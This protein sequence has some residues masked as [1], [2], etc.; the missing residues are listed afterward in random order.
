LALI[1]GGHFV[2]LPVLKVGILCYERGRVLPSSWTAWGEL[3]GGFFPHFFWTYGPSVTRGSSEVVSPDSWL[4]SN[5]W[6][7]CPQGRLQL[8]PMAAHYQFVQG[9]LFCCFHQVTAALPCSCNSGWL[10]PSP[11]KWDNSI[12]CTTLSP[13][14]SGQRSTMAPLWYVG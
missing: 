6:F 14:R 4:V 8:G 3:A 7:L 13:I 5:I 2:P 10:T 11:A 9:G 12:L 1:T